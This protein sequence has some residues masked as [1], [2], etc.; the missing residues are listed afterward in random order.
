MRPSARGDVILALPVL[1]DGYTD[2]RAGAKA[3]L[4]NFN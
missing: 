2:R 4:Q 3:R 1:K